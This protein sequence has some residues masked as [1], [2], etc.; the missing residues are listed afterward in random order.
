MSSVF[1]GCRCV[2]LLVFAVSLV[3]KVRS[4][5]SFLAFRAA[6]TALLPRSA[7]VRTAA[8]PVAVAVVGAEA[9]VVVGLAVPGVVWAGVS[10]SAGLLAS[11]TAAIAAALRRGTSASCRCFGGSTRLGAR[12]LVRNGV[13]L[14]LAGIPLLAGQRAAGDPVADPVVVV[15]T[16][17]VAVVAAVLVISFDALV[18]LFAG[19]TNPSVRGVRS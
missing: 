9:A 19:P 14:V 4:R 7:V 13:L 3:S 5:Q 2:L 10:L 16:I 12:H 18:D 17:G 15:M 6:T 8:G 11:F 1:L